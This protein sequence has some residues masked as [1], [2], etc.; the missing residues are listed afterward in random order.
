MENTIT[1]NNPDYKK[2]KL[3]WIPEDWDVAKFKELCL[4]KGQ[5]GINAS[6]VNFSEHLPAYLRITDIDDDGKFSKT[7]KVSVDDINYKN[8][9]LIEGDIVFVR[10]GATVGKTYLYDPKDGELVYAGFLIKFTPNKNKLNKKYLKYYTQ[11]TSYWNWVRITSVR[12]G[13]PGINETEY[14][15]MLLPLAPLSEQK[16]IANCLSTW[17]TAITKLDALIKAKQKLKKALMQQLLSGKKRLPGF[18]G[19]WVEKRVDDFANEYSQKNDDNKDIEVLSC[20]KYDGLVPSLEYFG[21]QVFGD[22]LT[23]YKVVPRGYFAYATNHIEEGSIGYQDFNE[24]GLVSPMYTVFK[25]NETVDDNYLFKVLKSHKL[26]HEYNRRME[27]SI[28]RRGGLRWKNFKGIK[29]NLA[30]LEEQKAIAKVLDTADQEINLLTNQRNQ[31]QLQKKG[32][33]QQLLTGKKRLNT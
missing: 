10:T 29:I 30:Q 12:S 21:R 3:G 20:T 25:T 4:N 15:E 33:M 26:I 31:L 13:Q 5:Y 8:F 28:D 2:T 7:K 22:N 23:K 18:E 17:D 27:G 24:L 6:A 14:G 19:E 16:A 11:T 9:I 32:L 1:E